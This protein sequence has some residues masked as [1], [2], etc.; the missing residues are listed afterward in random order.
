MRR[1]QR[2][3][4]HGKS[5]KSLSEFGQQVKE[6]QKIRFTYGIRESQMKS[7]V[8]KAIKNPGVTGEM[9]MQMLERRLDNVVF[10]M[11]LAPSRSVARQIVNH[12]HILVNDRKTNIP[13]YQ[14]RVNDLI[15]IRPQSREYLLFKDLAEKL[16]KYD[17]PLWIKLESDKLE[18][19][20][21]ALPK[22]SD[23]SFDVN[24]VVDY[25]SK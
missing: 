14:V 20:V 5:Y 7:L 6:K 8:K 12:G 10:R 25:Y 1:A 22:E 15:S 11:G 23:S 17:A 4:Q 9:I 13:S 16:K 2:P 21:A 3:G 19:K 18:G 24:M